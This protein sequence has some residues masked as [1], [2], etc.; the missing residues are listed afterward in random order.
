LVGILADFGTFVICIQLNISSSC[1]YQNNALIAALA[2][3]QTALATFEA[4]INQSLSPATEYNKNSR[5]TTV[6]RPLPKN[7]IGGLYEKTYFIVITYTLP[8]SHRIM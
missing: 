2:N 1:N 7:N 6:R 4:I 3:K 8:A 5:R